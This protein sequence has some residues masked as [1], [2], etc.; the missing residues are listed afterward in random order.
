MSPSC[1]SPDNINPTDMQSIYLLAVLV[2]GAGLAFQSPI[3]ARLRYYAGSPAA[4]AFIS[5]L[6]GTVLLGALTIISNAGYPL[7][8]DRLKNAPWWIFIGGALG[9]A[10]VVSAMVSIPHIGAGMLLAATVTGQ[11]AAAL[12]IDHNG[13]FGLDATALTPKRLAGAAL[14]GVALWCLKK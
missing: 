10:Y 13:W 1:D 12:L 6:I 9:V 2:A 14:L 5:F 4:G 8:L 11:M 3:N 7:V